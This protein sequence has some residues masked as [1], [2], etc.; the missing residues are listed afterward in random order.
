MGESIA[1]VCCWENYAIVIKGVG[2]F[3]VLPSFP[4]RLH[5]LHETKR[6]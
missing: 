5:I 3:K 4:L 1:N 2:A 6:H